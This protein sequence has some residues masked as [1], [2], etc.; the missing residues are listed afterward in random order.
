M[1]YRRPQAGAL[2]WT[3]MSIKFLFLPFFLE[4]ATVMSS[5]HV[6]QAPEPETRDGGFFRLPSM[7]EHSSRRVT[8]TGS[9]LDTQM[10]V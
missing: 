5:T 8:S 9:Q 6:Y 4:R 1:E 7:T 10:A 2:Y 3:L